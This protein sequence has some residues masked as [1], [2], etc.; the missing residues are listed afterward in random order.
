MLNKEFF[1]FLQVQIVCGIFLFFKII[2][3]KV[4]CSLIALFIEFKVSIF[5]FSSS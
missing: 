1:T 3:G 5:N 2:F 4:N